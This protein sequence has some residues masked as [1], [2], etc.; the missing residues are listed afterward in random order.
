MVSWFIKHPTASNL[1]M[2]LLLLLGVLTMSRIKREVMPDF[3]DEKV[4]I[5]ISYPGATAEEAE[6]AICAPVEEALENVNNVKEVTSTAREGT[7]TIVVEME[8]GS[9]FMEFY[10]DIKTEVETIDS[11]PKE[12]DKI[13][14]KPQNRTDHVFSVAITGDMS[15]IDLKEYCELLKGKLRQTVGG[16]QVEVEGFSQH[17]FRI[18]LSPETLHAYKLSVNDIA[19]TIKNQNADIPSGTLETGARDILL[20]FNDRRKTVKD[21]A[22][23]RI[24]SGSTGAEIKLGDIAK[25]TDRFE[26]DEQKVLFNGKRAGILNISKSKSRDSL[27]V[28]DAVIKLVDKAKAQAPAGVNFYVTRNA[29]EMIRDRLRLLIENGIQGIILVFLT[30]WL[31]LNIR[32]A[33]WVSMGLP[34]SFLGGVFFMHLFGVSINMISMVALLIAIGLLMDDAIV[35]SENIAVRLRAGDKPVDAAVNGVKEVASGVISSFITTAC[36]F[37]PLMF[38]SGKL[39]KILSV[40]PVTLLLVLSVSMLEAFFIMPNHLAHSFKHGMGKPF[41]L[42]IY[43]NRAVDWIRITLVG[44]LIR[45]LIPHRYLF[46]GCVAALFVLSLAMPASGVLKFVAFPDVDG[47]T[48]STKVLLPPGTPLADSEKAAVK[49]VEAVGKVNEYFKPVQPGKVDLIKSVSIQFSVNNNADP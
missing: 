36:V 45:R 10:N 13:I 35:L 29:A 9:S 23:M 18:E 5:S 6:E 38:T 26:L 12:V 42:R 28:Y 19:D 3:S 48:V 17:E 14:I 43:I 25:I 41:G 31:F 30:L 46:L 7:G 39:G 1:L 8:E 37:C 15:T 27:K 11:F 33:F 49:L 4:S 44:G 20:R 24:V 40:I 16:I 47:D 21:L 2:C 22:D 32:L 34:I